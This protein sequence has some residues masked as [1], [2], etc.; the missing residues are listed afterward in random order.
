MDM[1]KLLQKLTKELGISSKEISSRLEIGLRT[2][3]NY[4]SGK[5]Q[6][7]ESIKRLIQYEFAEFL[8]ED[9]RLIA[10]LVD[11]ATLVNFD[12]LK[13]IEELKNHVKSLE[14][15]LQHAKDTVELQKKT[16][17]LL[18]DQVQL[19]KDRLNIS[20]GSNSQQTG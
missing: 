13:K 6:I 14:K 3:Q 1:Q 11:V 18:E 9:E 8:T 17:A 2:V 5:Q 16:I 20:G 19:Y 10:T 7:P 12:D 15:D 4:I